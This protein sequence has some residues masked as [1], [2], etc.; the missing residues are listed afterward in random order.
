MYEHIG[1]P[2]YARVAADVGELIAR[3]I[4]FPAFE[5]SVFTMTE[6][7]FG[8]VPYPLHKNLDT[9]FDTFELLTVLGFWNHKAG[10]GIQFMDGDGVMELIPGATVA[11]PTG[12]KG[13]RLLPIASHE[14]R[15]VFRQYCHASVLRWMTK[16]GRSDREFDRD[17]S[18]EDSLAWDEMRTNHGHASI[19]MFS[20]LR[21][22]FVL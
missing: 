19:K 3:E 1:A 15:Y 10:G 16:G 5:H 4:V 8:N 22:I 18:D 7:D 21:D 6:I 9:V 14:K 13:Y 12:T 11:I 2:G 17:A 20:K